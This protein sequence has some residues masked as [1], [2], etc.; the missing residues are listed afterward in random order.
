[1]VVRFEA[2]TPGRLREIEDMMMTPLRELGVGEAA[3]H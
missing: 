3:A 2:R 1:V